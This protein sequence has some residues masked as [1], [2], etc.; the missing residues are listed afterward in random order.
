MDRTK[1]GALSRWQA[2]WVL[3][4]P[5]SPQMNSVRQSG[6]TSRVQIVDSYCLAI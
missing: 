2:N 4:V 3:P 1:R 6:R 5:V